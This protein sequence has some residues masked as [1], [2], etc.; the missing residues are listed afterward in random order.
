MYIY[1]NVSKTKLANHLRLKQ[2][3]VIVPSKDFTIQNVFYIKEN[4]NIIFM[5]IDAHLN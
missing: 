4:N 3:S 5:R 2:K 1:Q